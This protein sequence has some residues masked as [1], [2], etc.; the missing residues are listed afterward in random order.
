MNSVVEILRKL[1]AFNTVSTEP[2]TDAIGYVRSF[3]GAL[4]FTSQVIGGER[5]QCLIAKNE[6]ALECDRREEKY[7]ALCAHIDTVPF[8]KELWATDPLSLEEH[9]GKLYGIGAADMKGPLACM[10]QSLKVAGQASQ[11][12]PLALILTH[13]EEIA[14]DGAFELYRSP[15]AMALMQNMQLI[16]GEPTGLEI[17]YA[18]KGIYDFTITI[19]GRAAHSGKPDEGLNAVYGASVLAQE[20]ALMD[21]RW[22]D[23][24]HLGF[25]RGDTVNVGTFHAGDIRNRVPETAILTGDMR[26]LPGSS[27]DAFVDE[28]ERQSETLRAKGYQCELTGDNDL[29]PFVM[30]TESGLIAELSRVVGSKPITVGYATDASV[31]QALAGLDCAIIGPGDIAVC[32]RPNEYIEKRQLSSGIEMYTRILT[33]RRGRSERT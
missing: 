18:H 19:R 16:I 32:H 33:S 27:A 22:M 28:V 24:D 20:I 29:K 13:H 26:F 21:A 2:T 31:F 7:L 8:E 5:F 14:L 17:G 4:G 1:I 12:I 30:P 23:G 3:V 15:D 9:D 10:L 6:A 11:S 25:E